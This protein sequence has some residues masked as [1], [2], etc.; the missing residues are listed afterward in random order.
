[1]SGNDAVSRKVTKNRVGRPRLARARIELGW[2]QETAADE[3]CKR[4]PH[5]R[6]DGRQIGRWESGET[7]NPRPANIWAV[8]KTYGVPPDELDLPSI[9]DVNFALDAPGATEPAEHMPTSARPVPY[10]DAPLTVDVSSAGDE[11]VTITVKRR[12]FLQA[13]GGGLAATVLNDVA[14]H[15]TRSP[16]ELEVVQAI[17][18]IHRLEG[19][20]GGETID[21]IEQAIADLGL[22]HMLSSAQAFGVQAGHLLAYVEALIASEQGTSFRRRLLSAAGWAAGL[23]ANA[24]LDSGSLAS[25]RPNCRAALLYGLQAEDARLIAWAHDRHAKI[26]FYTDDLIGVR[27]HVEAGLERAPARSSGRVG[28]LGAQARLLARMGNAAETMRVVNQVTREYDDLPMSQIGGGLF[29]ISEI[30]PAACS[31]QATVWLNEPEL[32]IRQALATIEVLDRAPGPSRRPTRVAIA[33]LD[34]ATALVQ[35]EKPDEACHFAT[36]AINTDRIAS[37]VVLRAARFGADLLKRWPDLPDVRDFHERSRLL[38]SPGR[39]Q[40]PAPEA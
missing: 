32:T 33:Q 19:R 4:F 29:L 13:M 1:M 5:I 8:S 21:G 39:R 35:Q 37:S 6:I 12:E 15:D 17:E 31:S 10:G 36:L 34:I 11:T 27:R 20:L 23:L 25:A 40:L 30:Y 28:L 38:D 14:F 24:Q 7:A 2:S 9:G 22:M 3:V 16:R 18:R 26:C